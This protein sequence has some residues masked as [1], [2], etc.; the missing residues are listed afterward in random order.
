MGLPQ[1]QG[2]GPLPTAVSE[3]AASA[4]RLGVS[5][6]I[7]GKDALERG[8]RLRS[9]SGCRGA[10]LLHSTVSSHT[11]SFNKHSPTPPQSHPSPHHS[12]VQD[13]CSRIH[14]TRPVH[15]DTAC[16]APHGMSPLP[17]FSPLRLCQLP[18]PTT[19]SPPQ[20][21]RVSTAPVPPGASRLLAVLRAQGSGLAH[22]SDASL[23][24][25]IFSVTVIAAIVKFRRI[26]YCSYAIRSSIFVYHRPAT[27]KAHRDVWTL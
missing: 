7:L 5:V 24:I 6:S 20:L 12:S 27:C 16:K 26:V 23:S 3:E 13:K 22:L 4:A 25:H 2:Q 15:S 11:H 1:T 17:P 14:R 10:G 19:P 21:R 9:L 8:P 18:R